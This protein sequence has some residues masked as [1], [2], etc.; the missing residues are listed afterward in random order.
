MID[1][2]YSHGYGDVVYAYDVINEAANGNVT[3]TYDDNGSSVSVRTNPGVTTR[4][5]K[6]VTSE[7]QC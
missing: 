5:G 4:S 3:F 1:Y 2:I 7:K 6:K